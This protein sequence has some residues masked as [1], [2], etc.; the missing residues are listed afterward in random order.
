MNLNIY[1]TFVFD[2]DGVIL[3]SNKIKSI[4]FYETALLFGPLEA[5]LFLKYHQKNAGIS[6][7]KKFNFL[8]KKIKNSNFTLE[9]LLSIYSNHVLDGLK[10]AEVSEGLLNLR[11]QYINSNWLIA[12]GGDQDELRYIFKK[13]SLSKLFN[14][15]I[16]GS[17]N[18]KYTIIEEQ[19][20]IGNI[21]YPVI[22]F[23][24]SKY[25]YEVSRK[26]N[27]DFIFISNWT[28]FRNWKYF[29]NKNKILNIPNLSDLV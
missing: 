15:G 16:F 28:E 12:S 26:F 8:L 19:L 1:K 5:N 4:A 6:R 20:K 23:G 3:N 21:T 7:Y 22:Y 25:D 11:R 10:N 18:D 17:P 14:N 24:D 9:K 2:C 13:K 27:F 29:C